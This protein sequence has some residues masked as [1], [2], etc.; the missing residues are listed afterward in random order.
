MS[1]VLNLSE[2]IQVWYI[3]NKIEKIESK[4][5]MKQEKNIGS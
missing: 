3:Q 5:I 4:R 2:T 1:K